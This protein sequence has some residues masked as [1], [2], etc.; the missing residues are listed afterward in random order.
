[1]AEIKGCYNVNGYIY[2]CKDCPREHDESEC[3]DFREKEEMDL[4][5]II[6]LTE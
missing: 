5:Y 6:K 2:I 3:E 1:M 4:L